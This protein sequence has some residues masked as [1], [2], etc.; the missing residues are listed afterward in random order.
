MNFIYIN[1]KI[2]YLQGIWTKE[3]ALS[4]L[5]ELD[6]LKQCFEQLSIERID[7]LDTIGAMLIC[8]L[9]ISY[10]AELIADVTKEWYSFFL[11]TKQAVNNANIFSI[12]ENL[13]K[14][15]ILISLFYKIGC[16]ANNS[17]KDIIFSLNFLGLLLSTILF[18]KPKK[19][20]F[21]NFKQ[22]IAPY[23][24]SF[25]KLGVTALPII[26][27][28]SFIIGGVMAQQGALQLR[29][30]GAEIYVVNLT[31]ILI[32]R[33]LGV[34]LTAILIA[35]RCGS[36][37]TGELGIMNMQGEI[38]ALKIMG[39]DSFKK[40]YLP[41]TVAILVSLPLLTLFA[42]LSALLGAAVV[43]NIY[44]H[45]SFSLFFNH[46]RNGMYYS[47]YFVGLIKAPFLAL[48][49]AII[50][51]IESLKVQG[52]SSKLANHIIACVVKSI[53]SVIVIDAILAIIISRVGY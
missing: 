47:T 39:V 26:M 12:Q 43:T 10:K 30:F 40:L 7:S 14:D 11:E 53:F 13:K 44:S 51:I 21:I 19:N 27:L 2:L 33:E 28:L 34:L 5:N 9:Q 4:I 25:N 49:I 6:T 48:F 20:Q 32:F 50:S 18:K 38:A 37:I 29:N 31:A 42:N 22:R 45:I 8:K 46:L 3:T 23:I 52:S 35:G 1:N 41:R 16:L 17:A 15:S 24:V 36:A